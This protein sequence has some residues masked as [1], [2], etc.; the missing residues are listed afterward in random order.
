MKRALA[1]F[2]A[3]LMTLLTGA[4][5]EADD[6]GEGIVHVLDEEQTDSFVQETGMIASDPFRPDSLERIILPP[7][8]RK[9]VKKPKQYPYSAIAY[10][11]AKGECGC[12]WCCTGFMVTEKTLL[13]AAHCMMCKEHEKWAKKVTFYFGYKS[14]KNY[15]YRYKSKW[16][17][18]VGSFPSRNEDD[19]AIVKLN[20]KVGKKTGWFGIRSCSDDDLMGKSFCIAGFGGEDK[21]RY[22]WGTVTGVWEKQLGYNIDTLPGSSGS[23]IFDSNDYAIGINTSHTDSANFGQRLR[24]EIFQKMEQNGLL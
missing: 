7:D 22:A 23:P 19:W 4:C 14:R 18:W 3:L 20:K 8:D 2:L 16:T 11:E 5:A 24:S 10:M 6:G 17:A 1:L 15:L 13:T 9:V 21:L 12:E